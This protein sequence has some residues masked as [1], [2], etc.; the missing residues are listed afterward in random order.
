MQHTFYRSP[1]NRCHFSPKGG[2]LFTK[3]G[4]LFHKGG[5]LFFKSQYPFLEVF[6]NQQISP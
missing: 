6:K 3:R 1:L 5:H 4:Y 2:H